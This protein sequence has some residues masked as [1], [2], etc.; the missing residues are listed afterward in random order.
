MIRDLRRSQEGRRT[1]LAT[2]AKV[3]LSMALV[4]ALGYGLV[5]REQRVRERWNALP[6]AGP[7][8]TAAMQVR[9]AAIQSLL[10]DEHVWGGMFQAWRERDELGSKIQ[11]HQEQL[12]RQAREAA[13][14]K[15]ARLQEAEDLRERG[16]RN[17]KDSHFAEA[18]VDLR[19]ALELGGEHWEKRAR[20][21][22]DIAAIEAW[23]AEK[24]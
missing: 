19:Q 7:N 10:A 9:L 11:R 14:E 24:P 13:L 18:L 22:A 1:N 4:G 15:Q 2:F 21:Q 5:T 12:S 3:V 16:M 23:K 8:D 6:Q 20:V 17:V